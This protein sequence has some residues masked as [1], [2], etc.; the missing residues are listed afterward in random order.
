MTLIPRKL[1]PDDQCIVVLDTS[2]ARDLAY[3][4]TLPDWV[5]TFEKMA[6]AGYSFSLADNALTELLNQH[7]DG[8]LNETE[9]HKIL[10][11]LLRFVNPEVPV[12]PGK[13]ELL[14][15][16]GESDDSTWSEAE[17]SAFSKRAWAVLNDPAL[18]D[19]VDRK[20][21]KKALQDDRD[22]WKQA[23]EDFDN[24]HAAWLTQ[25]P[26]G[27]TK[28][29][30]NEYAHPQ[31]DKALDIIASRGKSQS[32]SMAERQDLQT[33]YIWRQ[34]VRTRKAK[35]PY[36]PSSEKKV[37]DGIDLDLYRYLMLPAFVV[38]GDAGFHGKIADIK[39]PQR[40]WF[41]RPEELA[42]AWERGEKPRPTWKHESSDSSK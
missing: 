7:I 8:R 11:A 24:A 37:N 3:G 19:E 41:W 31:L 40:G 18:L 4:P 36:D 29:P 9:L 2:P 10:A 22:D 20:N 17:V 30:L 1:I 14:A 12:L 42:A 13:R 25:D 15:M 16:I 35:D 27:E 21:L 5:A 39:S 23:F 6:N 26:N 33:R 38:A 28:Q 34:W 32:P